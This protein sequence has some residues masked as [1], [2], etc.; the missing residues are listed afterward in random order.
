MKYKG[1]LTYESNKGIDLLRKIAYNV[2]V[3]F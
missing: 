2:L 1:T 3:L